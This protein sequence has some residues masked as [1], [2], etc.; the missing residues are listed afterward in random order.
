[1]RSLAV[2][3]IWLLACCVPAYADSVAD[4]NQPSSTV[5]GC[6]NDWNPLEHVARTCEGKAIVQS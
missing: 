5:P 6:V 1:M 4:L 3:G 2:I